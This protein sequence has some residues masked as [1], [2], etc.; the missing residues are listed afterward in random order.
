M[1]I[2]IKRICDQLEKEF[3]LIPEERKE[4]LIS[5]RDYF[6]KKFNANE[7]PK[8]IVICTHNSRRS[9]I[10]QLWLEVGAS[11]YGLPEIETFSGGTEATAF[12]ERAVKAFQLIGFK[13]STHDETANNPR[14]EIEWKEEMQP[15][16]AFSKKYED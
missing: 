2:K 16:K 9:H 8:L 11:Y 10:G 14:Y 4:K 6:S 15:Y 7:I 3:H 12:N 5:L 1:N 13:I